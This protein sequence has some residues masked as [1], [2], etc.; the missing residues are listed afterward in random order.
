MAPVWWVLS[1]IAGI[2]SFDNSALSSNLTAPTLPETYS[3]TEFPV[4][5]QAQNDRQLRS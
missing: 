3:N 4:L 5:R 1:K 2:S